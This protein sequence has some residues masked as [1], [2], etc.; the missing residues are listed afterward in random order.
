MDGEATSSTRAP[1]RFAPLPVRSRETCLRVNVLAARCP[2]GLPETHDRYRVREL[3]YGADAYR[4]V[5]FA[6][7]APYPRIG[8]R[9]APPRFAHVVL[10]GGDLTEA[11]HFEWPSGPS[12]RVVDALERDR[13]APVILSIGS[14]GGHR[15]TLVL[16]PAFPLGG[17]DA[18]HVIFRWDEGAREYA[19]SLHAW[20]PFDDCV[21]ILRVLVES[22]VR[23]A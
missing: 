10:K 16:A 6:A 11:F 5:E 12:V 1:V 2:A 4:V 3:H 20:R 8:P 17:V 21:A 22:V 14:I 18:D 19:L 15:G 9:N 13:Q 23:K 7:N